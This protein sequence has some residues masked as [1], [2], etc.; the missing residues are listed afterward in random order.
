[1]G[2]KRLLFL[3]AC[4]FS[5]GMVLANPAFAEKVTFRLA[6]QYAPDHTTTI[7]INEFVKM[8]N[9]RTKGEVTIKVYPAN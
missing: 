6:G 4:L 9:E 5:A 7:L 2:I 8:V 3:A 1:M